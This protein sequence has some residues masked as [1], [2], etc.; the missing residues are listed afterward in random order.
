MALSSRSYVE[1]QAYLTSPVER[2]ALLWLGLLLLPLTLVVMAGLVDA[3][4]LTATLRNAFRDPLG[5][6]T[7]AG[8]FAVAFLFRAAAW[9]T[10]LPSLPFGQA[11]AAIH[12]SLAGNHLLP[13]RL[14]EPFRMVSAVR[15]SGVSWTEATASTLT[16]RSADV[17]ALAGL[18]VVLGMGSLRPWL[19]MGSALLVGS[20]GAWWMRTRTDLPLPGFRALS[21]TAAAWIFE[22]VVVQRAAAWAGWELTWG[23]ALGVTAAA[24]IAQI[25]AVAPAGLGTYEAGAVAAL[26]AFGIPAG[27]GLAIA[28][29]AHGLKTGY[30]L[31]MGL[32]ALARPRPP[33]WGRLRLDPD[34]PRPTELRP[35]PDQ[36]APIVFFF[37]AHDEEKTVAQVVSRTP[38]RVRGHPVHPLV[39]DDGSADK[40]AEL[41]AAAG[42][43]VLRLPTNRGLGAA[44]REGFT[45][46]LRERPAAVAFCDADGEY[47]PEE[48][49][50]VV[51]P[52]LDGTAD[53]V[54]GSRFEG[55]IGRMLPH[56]RLG[57]RLLTGALR[58]I[59]R[60]PISDGQSGY[61][62]LSAEAAAAAEI[63]HDFNYAQVLTLDLLQKGF[64]YAEVPIGYSFRQSGRSFVR[65]LQYLRRVVPAVWRELNSD[66]SSTT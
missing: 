11:W 17:A 43:R 39:V 62:A 52:I 1:R 15:R 51:A 28:L 4:R 32:I 20:A 61:R 55:R 23:R 42:A 21:L 54:V 3:V 35:P 56:R 65:P 5:L 48:L 2:R 33:L 14:G 30:S 57:N 34:P 45:A 13:F 12:V 40:T 66:Q 44:V 37:P 38:A 18:G 7:A 25:L 31:V 50:A 49:E 26:A 47:A 60:R 64:R 24:V 36:D 46:A 27:S 6:V 16:L 22:A 8:G 19:V 10:V 29:T 53:Y 58:W 41:A 9:K 59:A 63:I